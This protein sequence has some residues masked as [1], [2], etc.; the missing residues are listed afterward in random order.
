MV[1]ATLYI[2]MRCP[3]ITIEIKYIGFFGHCG[4]VRAHG[5]RRTG[6]SQGTATHFDELPEWGETETQ[7]HG[8]GVSVTAT[9]LWVDTVQLP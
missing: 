8:D 4:I 7:R 9:A 5:K 2:Y 3:Y 6:Q 1:A